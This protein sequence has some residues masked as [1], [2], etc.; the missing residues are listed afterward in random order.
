MARDFFKV[1]PINWVELPLANFDRWG[2]RIVSEAV[3]SSPI[4]SVPIKIYERE[5]DGRTWFTV[6]INSYYV[7]GGFDTIEGAKT[8]ATKAL[9]ASISELIRPVYTATEVTKV[10]ADTETAS[11]N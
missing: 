9:R 5:Q 8:Y 10:E 3:L 6:S 7:S 11:N 1:R 4:I 2:E